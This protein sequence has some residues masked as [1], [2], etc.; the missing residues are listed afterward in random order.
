MMLA[1]PRPM[2]W[3][4]TAWVLAVILAPAAIPLASLALL[5]FGRRGIINAGP[6]WEYLTQIFAS[7]SCVVAAP[8]VVLLAV[9]RSPDDSAPRSTRIVETLKTVA[10]A[11]VCLLWAAL[12]LALLKDI[13]APVV[14]NALLRPKVQEWTVTVLDARVGR[15]SPS[16]DCPNRLS[17]AIP[18][19]WDSA[20]SVCAGR[21]SP[22]LRARKGDLLHLKGRS[23]PFGI[24]YRRD[25]LRLLE[26][27]ALN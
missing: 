16:R 2:R 20:L 4:V 14:A 27:P 6:A 8:L 21:N 25:D 26:S 13:A 3:L 17:F 7:A 19:V 15:P 9:R 24:T 23:G 22:L 12:S 5:P 11:A 18:A 10:L 1:L